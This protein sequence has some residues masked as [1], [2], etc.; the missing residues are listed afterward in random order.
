MITNTYFF[1]AGVEGVIGP[2]RSPCISSSGRVARNV[3]D[4]GK[5]AHVCL[6]RKHDP[7]VSFSIDIFGSPTTSSLL[8]INFIVSRLT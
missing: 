1:F 3:L 6:P 8:A 7:H 4:C 5:L 2:Q